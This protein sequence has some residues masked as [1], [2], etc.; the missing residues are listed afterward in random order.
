[1]KEFTV[2]LS[3]LILVIFGCGGGG[4]VPDRDDRPPEFCNYFGTIYEIGESFES[5]DGCNTCVCGEDGFGVCTEM[6]CDPCAGVEL[7]AC[8]VYCDGGF[9][10]GGEGCDSPGERCIITVIGDE[11]FCRPDFAWSC[12]VHPPLGMGCNLV[13]E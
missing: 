9:E 10:I 5:K 7:P 6:G 13:C 3:L 8:P 2:A 12:F 4:V 11:C 1:M